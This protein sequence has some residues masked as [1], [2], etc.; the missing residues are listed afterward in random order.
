MHMF[1]EMHYVHVQYEERNAYLYVNALSACMYNIE[2][3]MH[4]FIE[5]HYVHVQY[6]ERNAY[7]Y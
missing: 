6:R 4:I 1:I 3:A 2:N 5:M 7:L